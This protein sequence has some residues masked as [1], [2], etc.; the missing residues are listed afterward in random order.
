MKCSLFIGS[1]VNLAISA[2]WN[3]TYLYFILRIAYFLKKS[4]DLN[5]N[6]CKVRLSNEHFYI[7]LNFLKE[8]NFWNSCFYI[9]IIIFKKQNCTI[10]ITLPIGGLTH[11][12]THPNMKKWHIYS[13]LRNWSRPLLWGAGVDVNKWWRSQK[14]YGVAYAFWHSRWAL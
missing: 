14:Q 11:T 7:Y 10:I 5:T 6:S 8:M 4:K 13:Q 9:L 1:V 12:V 3:I 2:C